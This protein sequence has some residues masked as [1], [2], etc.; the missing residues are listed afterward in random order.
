[1]ADHV[2]R[3]SEV[4]EAALTAHVED[5]NVGRVASGLRPFASNDDFLADA[6]DGLLAPCLMTFNLAQTDAL[7]TLFVKA[8]LATREKALKALKP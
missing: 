7:T 8:D 2:I 5:L 3:L 6:V 1:M 4:V